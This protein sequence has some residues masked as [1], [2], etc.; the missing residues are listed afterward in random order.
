MNVTYSI[1][2]G[3]SLKKQLDSMAKKTIVADSNATIQSVP[4]TNNNQDQFVLKFPK[5]KNN[6]RSRIPIIKNGNM[7]KKNC[8]FI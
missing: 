2:R 8:Y 6:V 1:H 3:P 4:K 5:P 7:K